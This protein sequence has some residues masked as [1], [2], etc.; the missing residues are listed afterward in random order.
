MHQKSVRWK[1]RRFH[2]KWNAFLF[3]CFRMLS[4]VTIVATVFIGVFH[5]L[6]FRQDKIK[7][8]KLELCAFRSLST[9]LDIFYSL[10]PSQLFFF[11]KL[12]FIP[13]SWIL[14]NFRHSVKIKQT[15]IFYLIKFAKLL[16][17]LK[18]LSV[19]VSVEDFR[20]C[21]NPRLETIIRTGFTVSTIED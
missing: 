1:L 19:S 11:F 14:I 10:V 6:Y 17:E 5:K 4:L 8:I 13:S 9:D 12:S 15:T 20:Q 7:Q 21:D 2:R 3:W 16:M 18:T